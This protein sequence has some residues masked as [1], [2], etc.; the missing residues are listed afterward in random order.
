MFSPFLKSPFAHFLKAE[1]LIKKL[2]PMELLQTRPIK[3]L[4]VNTHLP[5]KTKRSQKGLFHRRIIQSGNQTCFSEKKTRRTWYPNVH[6]HWFYSE[7]LE[8]KIR[9]HVTSKALRCMRK[10]GSFDNYILLTSPKNLDSIYGEFLRRLML[11]KMND[12]GFKVPFLSRSTDP[13]LQHNQHHYLTR[14][15]VF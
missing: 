11:T 14:F 10:C 7:I 15:L 6:E 12:P 13:S 5:G 8:R 4:L 9:L 2:T 1:T 3:K